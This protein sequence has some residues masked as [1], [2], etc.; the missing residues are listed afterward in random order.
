M[1]DFGFDGKGVIYALNPPKIEFETVLFQDSME[2][3]LSHPIRT[4]EIRYT[5]DGSEPDSLASPIYSNPIWL[6]KNCSNPY[7]SICKGLDW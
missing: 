2:L 4:A 1:I 6:K 3:I 5:L 7:Q